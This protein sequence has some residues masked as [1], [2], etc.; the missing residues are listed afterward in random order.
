MRWANGMGVTTEIAVHPADASLDD[1]HW[2][3][4]V[5]RMV[6][7]TSFST[8]PGIDRTLVVVDGA[9]I[10]LAVGSA[11]LRRLDT[12]SEPFSFPGDMP[13]FGH[14]VNGPI[15]N[16]NVMTCRQH[17]NHHVER[18]VVSGTVPVWTTGVTIIHAVNALTAGV[19]EL[20]TGDTATVS[21][22]SVCLY[23]EGHEANAIIVRINPA[24]ESR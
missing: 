5:A 23:L 4:S 17:G 6:E 20:A 15:S 22:P 16:F 10:D 3:V 7:D 14:V 2:R 13:T 19:F 24:I 11:Q 18:V 21:G 1:F 12:S 8:M 9:G